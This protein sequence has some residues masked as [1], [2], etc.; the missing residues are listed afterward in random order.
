[1][2]CFKTPPPLFESPGVTPGGG[3]RV[4]QPDHVHVHVHISWP[5]EN[6]L[7]FAAAVARVARSVHSH[8]IQRRWMPE[9]PNGIQRCIFLQSCYPACYR[10]QV[11]GY[12]CTSRLQVAAKRNCNVY[13]KTVHS[14]LL[15]LNV[16]FSHLLDTLPNFSPAQSMHD[17]PQRT[18]PRDTASKEN[19]AGCLPLGHACCHVRAPNAASADPAGHC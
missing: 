9:K 14:Y 2:T 10:L 1:M 13:G 15:L 17:D 3:D 16:M 18:P 4:S 19:Y 7:L 12:S 6:C 8:S 5:R 11:A